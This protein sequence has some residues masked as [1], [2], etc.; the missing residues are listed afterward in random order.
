M[1][2]TL[3]I[4]IYLA[5]LI[6]STAINILRKRTKFY[7]LGCGLVGYCGDKPPDLFKIA[8]LLKYNE[9]RGEHATG[10]C[11][12]DHV[13]KD[14][15]PVSTFLKSHNF[16]FN[17][18][19]ETYRNNAI[20][21][22][23]RQASV[24][25]RDKKD[26]AHPHAVY[27]DVEN[28]KS[29][30]PILI[31]VHNGTIT[32]IGDLAKK[33]NVEHKISDNSDS[34][35]LFRIMSKYK[36]EEGFKVLSEY[37]GAA[38]IIFYPLRMKNTLFVHRDPQRELFMYQE[39]PTSVYI[40][41]I[42]EALFA[43]GG[44]EL[45]KDVLEFKENVV[46]KFVNGV[47]KDT[48]ELEKRIAYY[49]PSQYSGN[50]SK[51][52]SQAPWKEHNENVRKATKNA[53][54]YNDF[55]FKNQETVGDTKKRLKGGTSRADAAAP[56]NG[57]CWW[58]HRY[59]FNGHPYK[60]PAFF[61]EDGSAGYIYEADAL[62][63]NITFKK[64]WIF[65]G[66]L[67]RTEA[68]YK[69]LEGKFA[70]GYGNFDPRKFDSAYPFEVKNYSKYPIPSLPKT[71]LKTGMPLYI[72]DFIAKNLKD[73]KIT[74]YAYTPYLSDLAFLVASSGLIMSITRAKREKTETNGNLT[75]KQVLFELLTD[76]SYSSFSTFFKEALVRLKWHNNDI[77][78]A[79]FTKEFLDAAKDDGVISEAV[80]GEII[81]TGTSDVFKTGSVDETLNE[82]L[83]KYYQWSEDTSDDVEEQITESYA[84][85]FH[86]D[87][88]EEFNAEAN[89]TVQKEQM[90][91]KS[92]ILYLNSGFYKAIDEKKVVN[93]ADLLE[94]Y[95]TT[96]EEEY[97][98]PVAVAAAKVLH[99]LGMVSK[100]EVE[101]A[102]TVPIKE[103][104]S[105]AE[106][107]YRFWLYDEQR[108][109]TKQE[110][111]E[112]DKKVS[113]KEMLKLFENTPALTPTDACAQLFFTLDND[114]DQSNLNKREVENMTDSLTY[115]IM[116]VT[117]IDETVLKDKYFIT[118]ADIKKLL[119]L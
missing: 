87:D 7:T 118:K 5:Y 46:V 50:K 37:A 91:S 21:A 93:I 23:A 95:A 117:T 108:P 20:L 88:Q 64:E 80:H 100:G 116:N 22:H 101:R 79:A 42:P 40:S 82:V 73:N 17:L 62:D 113:S 84:N 38:T 18:P 51:V 94:D 8:L 41:S 28:V 43:I 16:V 49:T 106:S 33:H 4:Y 69:E 78:F 115:M 29:K 1:I 77:T 102:L 86:E 75:V 39:S 60:G 90:D 26:L 32:N 12:D 2:L 25:S 63:S 56:G 59:Y 47:I 68:D 89:L 27:L 98:R 70:D 103:A 76:T 48:F 119:H 44:Q 66:L 15:V 99:D 105:I 96:D 112:D 45:N 54:E 11:I 67:V 35:T 85:S 110:D 10:I 52:H 55:F 34:Q 92:E 30:K 111:D 3:F 65:R 71:L 61:S 97:V 53:V 83:D 74:K 81:A 104:M 114:K 9:K 24:G 13:W 19:P 72:P 107:G 6:V 31:G 36:T 57:F 14:A 109:E 58:N